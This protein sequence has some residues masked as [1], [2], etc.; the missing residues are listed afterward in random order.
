MVTIDEVQQREQED[1]DDVDEVPVEAEQLDRRV[2]SGVNAPLRAMFMMH[3][4]QPMPM[5]MCSACMPVSAKYR[6]MK[7]RIWF[8]M[9]A[10][11]PSTLEP[12]LLG[13]SRIIA[14]A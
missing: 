4:Q 3:E 7:M 6:T 12:A 14:L 5:I 13:N 11:S 9:G 10:S 8:A 1:P 2:P